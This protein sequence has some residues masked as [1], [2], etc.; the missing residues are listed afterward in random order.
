MH[1]TIVILEEGNQPYPR[2]PQC[3]IFL[4]Q[5]A[6]NGQNLSKDFF[7]QVTERK[8][9]HLAEEEAREEAE[10]LIKSYGTP[11]TPVTSFK[12]I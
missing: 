6:L 10:A 8:R 4:S 11:L 1:G 3:D 9:Y 5:K 7:L 2:C 12:Y